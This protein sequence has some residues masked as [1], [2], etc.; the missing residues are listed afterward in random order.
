MILIKTTNQKR[1]ERV[2]EKQIIMYFN[3]KETNEKIMVSY[4]INPLT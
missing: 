1:K 4:R 2:R 3:A